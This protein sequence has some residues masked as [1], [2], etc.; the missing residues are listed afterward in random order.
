[1]S[2]RPTRL[3]DDTIALYHE[4][5]RYAP[6]SRNGISIAQQTFPAGKRITVISERTAFLTGTRALKVHFDQPIERFNLQDEDGTWMTTDLQELAQLVPYIRALQKY[7]H[8]LVGGLGLGV[9]AH[10]LAQTAREVIVA[11]EVNQDIAAL[12]SPFLAPQVRIVV[13]D[14]FEYLRSVPRGAFEAAYFD[15]WRSTGEWTWQTM[16]VPLRRLAAG[17]I[18]KI[19]CWQE[20]EMLGQVG[21]G[22]FKYADVSAEELGPNASTQHYWTWRKGIERVH[23]SARLSLKGKDINVPRM[24]EIEEENSKDPLLQMMAHV[25]LT[26]VGT[27]QWERVFGQ[28]WD[29]SLEEAARRAEKEE[30]EEEE[31]R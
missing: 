21:R 24:V 19:L 27:P 29:K 25:F 11:V 5:P 20:N 26:K 9:A 23:T 16:V 3:L 31:R 30:E 14:L 12:V 4:L 2:R 22:L 28:W 8:L 10:L 13:A 7:P 17:R 1:M 18:R 15:I 6:V